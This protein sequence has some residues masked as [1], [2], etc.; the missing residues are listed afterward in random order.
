MSS[1]ADERALP[2][3][4]RGYFG[5]KNSGHIA[6]HFAAAW[7]KSSGAISWHSASAVGRTQPCALLMNMC[8][9]RHQPF[10]VVERPGAKA[11]RVG[12]SL[13]FAKDPCPAV[14]AEPRRDVRTRR[15]FMVP[16]FRL[17]LN[18]PK[19]FGRHRHVQRKRAAGRSLA[20]GAIA[21]VEQQ[22]KRGDFITDRAAGA[23]AGQG[24]RRSP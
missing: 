17:A 7:P 8:A 14:A 23:A 18:D 9:G 3:E 21:G 1:R 12:P 11:H 10:G 2:T 20:I 16:A 22:R 6:R 13:A 4:K 24:K 5:G 19:S 15:R